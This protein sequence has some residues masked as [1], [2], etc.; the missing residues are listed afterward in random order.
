MENKDDDLR[1]L[2]RNLQADVENLRN[3]NKESAEIDFFTRFLFGVRVTMQIGLFIFT[4]YFCVQLGIDW[5][6]RGSKPSTEVRLEDVTELQMPTAGMIPAPYATDSRCFTPTPKSCTAFFYEADPLRKKNISCMAW[7]TAKPAATRS[8]LDTKIWML[9]GVKATNDGVFTSILDY[10]IYDFEFQPSCTEPYLWVF[11]TADN[12]VVSEGKLDP[13]VTMKKYAQS[14]FLM[15]GGQY[16][17]VA[18]NVAQDIDL[19]ESVTN[20]TTISISS[21]MISEFYRNYTRISTA[22][23]RPGAFK[24]QQRVTKGGQTVL[25]LVAN[26][27]GWVGMFLGLSALSVVDAVDFFWHNWRERVRRKHIQN[28]SET[29]GSYSYSGGQGGQGGQRVELVKACNVFPVRRRDAWQ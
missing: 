21:M 17:M 24:I 25:E 2:I 10:V 19:D 5:R 15:Q 9:D 29:H 18:F 22:V 14:S 8:N 7:L 16:V 4:V 12:R 1:V 13:T 23:F 26:L 20:T 11:L 6:D 28:T 3:E 27:G